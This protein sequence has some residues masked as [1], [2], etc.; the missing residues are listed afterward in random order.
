MRVYNVVQGEEEFYC[1][2][3]GHSVEF[4]VI[5]STTSL[6]K[7]EQLLE[8]VETIEHEM[9]ESGLEESLFHFSYCCNYEFFIEEVDVVE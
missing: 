4:T 7:A 3:D 1:W 6:Q 5:F 8:Y 2:D 9:R